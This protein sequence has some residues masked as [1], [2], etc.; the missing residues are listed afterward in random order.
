[1]N[2]SD[3]NKLRNSA[4]RRAVKPLV[5]NRAGETGIAVLILFDGKAKK[6]CWL[7]S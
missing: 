3:K 6:T 1:M 2:S 4:V 7:V 5:R